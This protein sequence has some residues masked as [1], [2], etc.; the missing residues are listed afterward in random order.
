MS[1]SVR[2]NGA[3][4]SWSSTIFKIGLERYWGLTSISFGDKI[5]RTKGYGMQ[6][7]HAPRGRSA[8]KY[9][10]EPLKIKGP[11]S[12]IEAIR[13]QFALAAPDGKSVGL[14]SFDV[15][16]QFVEL[17]ETPISVQITDC[18]I[19]EDM[20]SHEENPDPLQDEMTFDVMRV[21][22]NGKTLYD[23]TQGI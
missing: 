6:R 10:V 1:D 18:K 8:G 12:T 5:E 9:T 19:A 14:P 20:S 21:I 15:N 3:M 11:K 13:N 7:S 4:H 22:R 17:G 16:L 23:S 2:I